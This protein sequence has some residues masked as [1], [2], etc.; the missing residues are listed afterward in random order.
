MLLRLPIGVLKATIRLGLQYGIINRMIFFMRFAALCLTLASGMIVFANE[1]NVLRTAAEIN[2]FFSHGNGSR[3]YDITAVVQHAGADPRRWLIVRDSTGSANIWCDARIGRLNRGQRVHF[4]GTVN[5]S[6]RRREPFS[7]ADFYEILG[8]APIAPPLNLKLADLNEDKH[9]LADV[10]TEGTIVEIANDEIDSNYGII[11]LKDNECVMPVSYKLKH[12]KIRKDDLLGARILV[13]GVFQRSVLGERKFTGPFI[14]ISSL[15]DLKIVRPRPADPFAAPQ[16]EE[17]LYLTPKEITRLDRRTVRGHVLA[18]WGVRH[19]MV[20]DPSERIVNVELS[21]GIPVPAVGTGICVV[22]Y[23]ETD[24][25]RVN[26]GRAIWKKDDDLPPPA[27]ETAEVCSAELIIAKNYM[28]EHDEFFHGKL[29]TVKGALTS[30]PIHESAEQ[31][32]LLDCGRHKVPVDIS[33]NPRMADG[34]LVGSEIEVTGRCLLETDNWRPDKPFPHIRGIALV[35]RS[36]ADFRVLARPPWLTTGKLLVV[37]GALLVVILCLYVR[38]R[39]QKRMNQLKVADRTQLAV[40]LHDSMSQNL[41][42]AALQITTV[43][44]LIDTARDKALRHLDIAEL[45]LTSCRKELRN[46]I[47]DLRSNA[48]DTDDMNDAIRKTLEHH[49]G[50]ASLNVRFNVPRERLSDNTAH[51]LIRI[52]RELVVNAVQHGKANAIRIAGALE[53]DRLLFSVTDDGVGFDPENRPGIREGHFGL[54]GIEERIDELGGKMEI[55]SQPDKG[56][57]ISIWIKSRC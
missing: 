57:R 5:T 7:P 56:A 50:G 28:T 17:R 47:W 23:P 37:I 48:L 19:V 16:L 8:E 53:K 55:R 11:L 1:T 30:I 21:E 34:L 43:K 26:L 27:A 54:Q 14:D 9:N 52:I 41:S 10:C 25:Y 39:V 33:A 4:K 18:V 6:H 35:P 44:N 46:C 3:R 38:N 15:A 20:R 36:A 22:G 32:L 13:T 29:I 12:M 31:R 49:L 42:G 24:L 51:A 40:E 2:R 45:T